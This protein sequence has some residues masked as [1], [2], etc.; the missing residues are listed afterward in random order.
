MNPKR[1][2]IVGRVASHSSLFSFRF[3]PMCFFARGI[4]LPNVATVQR[5]HDADA[6][7]HR[8]S[9]DVATRINAS[10]AACHSWASCSALGS[11]VIVG[12]GVLKGD[13]VATVR[14]RYWII[15]GP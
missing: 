6:R 2:G 10:I 12:A 11:F 7:K 13:E 9:A 14:Q 5:P 3:P 1:D 4:K 15:K 8:R